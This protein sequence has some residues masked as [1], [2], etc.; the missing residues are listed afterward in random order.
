MAVSTPLLQIPPE[1]QPLGLRANGMEYPVLTWAAIGRAKADAP[2]ALLHLSAVGPYAQLKALWAHVLT[3]PARILHLLEP[4]QSG[5]T[6]RV[7][8]S[9]LSSIHGRYHAHWNAQPLLQSGQ[10]HLSLTHEVALDRGAGTGRVLLQPLHGPIDLPLVV[11]LLDRHLALPLPPALA[12]GEKAAEVWNAALAVGAVTPLPA[13]GCRAYWIA[14]EH[15]SWPQCVV[16]A[17]LGQMLDATAPPLVTTYGSAYTV[18][19]PL[20]AVDEDEQETNNDNV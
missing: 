16:A 15:P 10:S 20:T 6:Q 7:R 9:R 2:A 3:M 14:T 11:T 17:T 18:G 5:G 12:D 1:H 19:V 8:A 13:F 4:C